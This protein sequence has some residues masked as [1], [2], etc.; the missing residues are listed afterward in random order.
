MK[1]GT[2]SDMDRMNQRLSQTAYSA[3]CCLTWGFLHVQGR[4]TSSPQM[5]HFK[6]GQSN[7]P[8]FLDKSYSVA[9]TEYHGR[10]GSL[11][12]ILDDVAAELIR[13]M[14]S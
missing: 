4:G 5:R 14:F 3:C 13:K 11:G 2:S 6:S 10:E 8:V 12:C 1:I 7:I 9:V